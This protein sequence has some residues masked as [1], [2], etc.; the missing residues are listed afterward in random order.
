L[1]QLLHATGAAAFTPKLKFVFLFALLFFYCFFF[2]LKIS[3]ALFFV[4]LL[5]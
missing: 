5:S 3:I 2:Y 1:L 4:A